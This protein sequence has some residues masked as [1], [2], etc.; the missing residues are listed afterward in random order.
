MTN[1][2]ENPHAKAAA[3]E[4]AT[5]SEDW[6][7]AIPPDPKGAP[8]EQWF[9]YGIIRALEGGDILGAIANSVLIVT[10]VKAYN[11]KWKPKEEQPK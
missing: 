6:P 2:F 8:R 1:I 3:D 11:D 4:P 7:L 5:S 9:E 10:L